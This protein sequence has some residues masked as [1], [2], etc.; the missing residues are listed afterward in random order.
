VHYPCKGCGHVGPN[1]Q[2][3]GNPDECLACHKAAP[4]LRAMLRES[5]VASG[6]PGELD[7]RAFPG[8][9]PI[10]YVSKCG[11]TLCAECATEALRRD[12]DDPPV[13]FALYYEGPPERCAA[14]GEE[15]ASAY[16]EPSGKGDASEP[17]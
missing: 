17:A 11:E 3:S 12:D 10:L 5:Y 15:L 13:G 2:E 4:R 7:A 1:A 6:K 8:G 9:Y 16:G 14:C